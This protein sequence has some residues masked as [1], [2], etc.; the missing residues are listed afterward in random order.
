MS[1]ELVFDCIPKCL[2]SQFLFQS[3][4][5]RWNQKNNILHY[6][7]TQNNMG[8]FDK[9]NV[10]GQDIMIVG[11]N[12][13]QMVYHACRLCFLSRASRIFH[14]WYCQVFTGQSSIQ[15]IETTF[16]GF[17]FCFVWP[18]TISIE[19]MKMPKNKWFIFTS[20]GIRVCLNYLFTSYWVEFTY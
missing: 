13:L 6:Q 12:L 10:L 19:M 1:W 9:K 5:F 7:K 14:I 3:S 8:N 4:I 17:S 20:E 11:I 2:K 15:V 18:C 16:L